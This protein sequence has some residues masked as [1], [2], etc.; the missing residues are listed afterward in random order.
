MAAQ[1]AFTAWSTFDPA[2]ISFLIG[3]FLQVIMRALMSSVLAS[4]ASWEGS[5]R[6]NSIKNSTSSFAEGDDASCRPIFTDEVSTADDLDNNTHTFRASPC[7]RL[8]WALL[9]LRP[10]G[11]DSVHVWTRAS[12]EEKRAHGSSR[13]QA[14]PSHPGSLYKKRLIS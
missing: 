1:V 12:R 14:T 9:T 5:Q 11:T 13:L 7:Q 8:R 2:A 4:E 10:R 3:C 6:A